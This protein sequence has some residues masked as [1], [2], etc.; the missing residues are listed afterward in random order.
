M[1]VVQPQGAGSV[2]RHLRAVRGRVAAEGDVVVVLVEGEGVDVAEG[3][4]GGAGAVT[5]KPAAAFAR[6]AGATPTRSSVVGQALL[7]VGPRVVAGTG[8]EAGLPHPTTH[9][10]ARPRDRCRPMAQRLWVPLSHTAPTLRTQGAPAT[11]RWA[12]SRRDKRP[13]HRGSN[14]C[15]LSLRQRV[16]R[17]TPRIKVHTYPLLG[18]WRLDSHRERQALPLR[19]LYCWPLGASWTG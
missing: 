12:Q 7:D 11:C 3:A 8:L 15:D 2:A 4:G 18:V 5:I 17:R 14:P 1:H 10:S 6:V 16:T 13:A 19:S 9:T